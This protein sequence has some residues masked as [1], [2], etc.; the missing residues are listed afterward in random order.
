M[1][2]KIALAFLI[3]SYL[4]GDA[5][6]MTAGEWATK[7]KK[8]ASSQDMAILLTYIEGVSEG[9][10]WMDTEMELEGKGNFFC[11][12][13][14][15]ALTLKQRVSMFKVVLNDRPYLSKFG[16]GSVMIEAYKYAFPCIDKPN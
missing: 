4:V 16:I 9:V 2:K 15:V 13:D 8:P 7:Y 5:Y 11:I 3:A 12:S 1:N 6:G 10:Q 14:N